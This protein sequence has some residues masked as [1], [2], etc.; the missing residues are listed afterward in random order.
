M[1]LLY[2]KKAHGIILPNT[3]A[4]KEKIQKKIVRPE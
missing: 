3:K 1:T 2:T 4:P